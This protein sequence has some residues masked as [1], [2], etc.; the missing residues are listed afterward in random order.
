M[1]YL[2]DE[3]LNPFEVGEGQEV[4][5]SFVV[6]ATGT[7]AAEH[8]ADMAFVGWLQRPKR[9][10]C[11][12]GGRGGAPDGIEADVCGFWSPFWY[13]QRHNGIAIRFLE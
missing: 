12:P 11:G 8:F 9:D 3:F 7:G 6:G 5:T 1:L 2:S 4:K 13:G 10:G